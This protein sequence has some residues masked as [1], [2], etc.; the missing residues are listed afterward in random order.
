MVTNGSLLMRSRYSAGQSA[1][2]SPSTIPRME[3]AIVKYHTDG[4]PS[5]PGSRLH[6]DSFA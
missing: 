5:Y 3:S 6:I 2:A 4:H 1:V